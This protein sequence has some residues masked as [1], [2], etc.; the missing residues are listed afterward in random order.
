MQ[1]TQFVLDLLVIYFART[2]A[3]LHVRN[4]FGLAASCD[5]FSRSNS[6]FL[7]SLGSSRGSPLPQPSRS[8]R[9]EYSRPSWFLHPLL[10][11][12][13]IH[14]SPITP[15][16]HRANI[17]SPT[18]L[19]PPLSHHSLGMNYPFPHYTGPRSSSGRPKTSPVPGAPNHGSNRLNFNSITRL[20]LF[21]GSCKISLAAHGIPWLGP[22]LALC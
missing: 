12:H 9:H 15:T 6:F 7:I 13:F 18:I 4:L 10:R 19:F 16:L 21:T 1:I 20:F 22:Q 14:R 11:F 17:H 3:I 2:S 8:N 5:C